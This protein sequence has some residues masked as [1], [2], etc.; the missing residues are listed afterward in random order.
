MKQLDEYIFA[1]LLGLSVA[2][3]F[4]LLDRPPQSVDTQVSAYCFAAAIPL[5]A[6]AYVTHHAAKNGIRVA[7]WRSLISV[8]ASLA[9]IAGFAAMVFHFGTGVFA[10]FVACTLFAF[11]AVRQLLR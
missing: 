6:V 9:S 10:V 1:G 4:H 7:R 11:V 3:V 5:L 8:I 2:G